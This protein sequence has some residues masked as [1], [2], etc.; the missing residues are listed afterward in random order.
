MAGKDKV[1]ALLKLKILAHLSEPDHIHD[2]LVPGLVIRPDDSIRNISNERILSEM[3]DA[4]WIERRNVTS[5]K[6]AKPYFITDSGLKH[7][8]SATHSAIFPEIGQRNDWANAIENNDLSVRI[9]AVLSELPEFQSSHQSRLSVVSAMIA[10]AVS[11][12]HHR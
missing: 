11:Q 7:L 4:G 3:V 8:E 6:T 5:H 12:N 9:K 10:E 1:E 2:G